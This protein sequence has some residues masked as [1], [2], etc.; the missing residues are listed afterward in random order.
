M[1]IRRYLKKHGVKLG[2]LVL[3]A[4]IIVAAVAGTSDGKAGFL[5]N[6]AGSIKAPVQRAAGAMVDWLEGI[7]GYLYEYDLL[8]EENESLR[9]RI[10]ELQDQARS[11]DEI[12]AENARLRELLNLR[13]KHTDFVFESAKIVS[14]DASN[15]TS[16]FT[17]SKGET[18]GIEVGDCV[19]TE[20]GA[21]VGQVVELG[22]T[23]AVVRTIIDIE[24][25]VGAAFGESG[26]TGMVSGDFSLMKEG[27]TRLTYLTAG[28][29]L[30][31]GDE[32][33]T[34][35]KGGAFPAGL[36]IGTVTT[37]MTEAGGQTTYGVVEPAC[38]LDLLAQ[39]FI[40]K[41]YDIVE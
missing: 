23:W 8:V 2:V 38:D 1:N 31:K 11:Y 6:A 12:E 32:V 41:D 19:V 20:Y 3:V 29:Q 35:G 33:M 5:S 28:S 37:I 22:D 18:S 34:S 40:V 10:A 15:F 26:Y 17:V 13:D 21:L 9:M 24:M 36:L 25:D 27:A 39:V 4:V 7:Y 30:F 16:A 14:W